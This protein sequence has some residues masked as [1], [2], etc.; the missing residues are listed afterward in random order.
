MKNLTSTFY[1]VIITMLMALALPQAAIGAT[2]KVTVNEMPI[3]DVQISQRAKL[4]KLER[5]GN[6]ASARLLMA[7]KELVDEELK[8]QEA[9]RLEM[10]PTDAEVSEAFLNVARNM[11]VS[12]DNLTRILTQNGVNPQT[13]K[14]RLRAAIAWRNVTRTAVQSRI[15]FSE[16]ELEQK[17]A[18][19][20][21]PADN[22]DYILK[23]VLFIIPAGS[24]ISTS[25]RTAQAN[26][27]RRSFQG[28]DSAVELSLSYTDAAVIDLGRRHATQLPETLAKELARLNVGGIT[29]PRVVSNGVSMLAICS[30]TAARD[31]SFATNKVRQEVGTKLLKAEAEKYLEELR[32]KANINNR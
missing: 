4:L 28:C 32:T 25:R 23:E 14:D 22:I 19:Q 31:L 21:T 20:L 9:K 29:K 2:V 24:K 7:R 8:M 13:L 18:A 11:R 3:T 16:T 26:Q 5:R 10:S 6:S 30:K 1:A 12:S 27:Y 17:A 15:Q